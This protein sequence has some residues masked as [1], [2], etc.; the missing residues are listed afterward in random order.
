MCVGGGRRLKG[1]QTF[2]IML[3][4]IIRNNNNGITITATIMSPLGAGDKQSAGGNIMINIMEEGRHTSSVNTLPY[5]LTRCV[6][7]NV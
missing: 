3:M 1:I 5:S 6:I 7:K 4:Q 2:I